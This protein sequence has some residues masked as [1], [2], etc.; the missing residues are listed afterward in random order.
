V[1]VREIYGLRGKITMKRRCKKISSLKK[2]VLFFA[3]TIILSTF[4]LCAVGQFSAEGIEVQKN[5][6]WSRLISCTK[7]D[8][9]R[10]TTSCDMT[11]D[12]LFMTEEEYEEYKD[13][14]T[15]GGS[16]TYYI[17]G[18]RLSVASTQYEF[19]IPENGDYYIVIDNT[20]LPLGGATPQGD[21]VLGLGVNHEKSLL[22]STF[23]FGDWIFIGIIII[24]C[25]SVGI[26][27]GVVVYVRGK[28]QERYEDSIKNL[29]RQ[30]SSGKISEQTYKE[31]RENIEDKYH[32]QIK[33]M[34]L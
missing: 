25:V 32:K 6:Y 13:A 20:D 30:L 8:K 29:D 23:G 34:G 19:E 24:G 31:L 18:S 28:E 33:R 21:I 14:I 2:T 26:I 12:I 27:I 7:G 4:L 15:N 11:F 22:G 5:S 16:F 3:F 9:I 1:R 10:I 17:T